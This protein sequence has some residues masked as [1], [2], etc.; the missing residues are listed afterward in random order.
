MR[1]QLA[2]PAAYE[3]RPTPQPPNAYK[4]ETGGSP[5]H[6]QAPVPISPISP[7]HQK[8]FQKHC[9]VSSFRWQ[10]ELCP[11]PA[12]F[13]PLAPTHS[14]FFILKESEDKAGVGVGGRR[15]V[16]SESFPC[17]CA[18]FLSADLIPFHSHVF[19]P[20]KAFGCPHLGLCQPV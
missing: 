10:W 2:T 4:A 11:P 14:R 9:P 6:A 8:T 16:F 17:I 20:S 15:R 12:L 1:V 13:P 5:L 19:L 18:F 3:P 7:L